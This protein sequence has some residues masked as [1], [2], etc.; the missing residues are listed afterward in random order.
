MALA[1]GDIRLPRIR[2]SERQVSL[3]PEQAMVF[4]K[5]DSSLYLQGAFDLAGVMTE[6][7]ALVEPAFRS[8]KGVG[9]GEQPRCLFCTVGRFFRPGYHNNLVQSWLLRRRQAA[10]DTDKTPFR[11]QVST[12]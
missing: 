2:R 12:R 1:S 3:P 4:A 5:T 6:N 11:N 7:Q 9:W 8:G 10:H